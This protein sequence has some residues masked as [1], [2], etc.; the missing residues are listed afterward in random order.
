MFAV[1][2]VDLAPAAL[3]ES[4]ATMSAFLSGRLVESTLGT[5]AV[6]V[7]SFVIARSFL[8]SELLLEGTVLVTVFVARIALVSATVTVLFRV[9]SNLVPPTGI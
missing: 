4:F 6:F 9:Q 1:P 2:M 7:M 3:V 8:S 5:A